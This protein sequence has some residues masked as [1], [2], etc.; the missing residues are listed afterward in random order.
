VVSDAVTWKV[1]VVEGL[2]KDGECNVYRAVN[3]MNFCCSALNP[4]VKCSTV[5]TDGYEVTNLVSSDAD[6]A[7]K[8][9]LAYHA[10][11]PPVTITI[12]FC[13]QV[14]VSHVILWAEV[15]YQKSSGFEIYANC[16]SI[17]KPEEYQK[18]AFGYLEGD[19]VGIIFYR[20]ISY[21][22]CLK[23]AKHL[24]SF[25]WKAIPGGTCCF[26][27]N[28]ASLQIKIIKTKSSVPALARVEVWGKPSNSCDEAVKRNIS[29]LWT[30]T[31]PKKE[32][33]CCE[34]ESQLQ[35]DHD[36]HVDIEIPEEFLDSITCTIMA[37]PFI[38]PC[39]KVVDQSTLDKHG[40][41][42]A[43][44]GR[45]PSDPFTGK[46]FTESSQP[47][48]ATALK[49][50][51][52]KFLI[53]HSDRHELAS[54]PRT[55]GRKKKSSINAMTFSTVPSAYIKPS[56]SVGCP[57]EHKE[58]THPSALED[59]SQSKPKRP[60]CGVDTWEILCDESHEEELDRSLSSAVECTLI[61]L[62]TFTTFN[63]HM[64]I[65][66][67]SVCSS[68]SVL[69]KLPCK[70]FV[71]RACLV[72]KKESSDLSCSVCKACFKSCDPVR[73]HV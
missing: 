58:V 63:S 49:A 20:R 16:A 69:F 23:S 59:V 4:T 40:Q 9:F 34:P 10:V 30:R 11:K 31:I 37:V 29:E 15:G 60:R 52:D 39:G 42:E 17:T 12:N 13:C 43:K 38:L 36:S 68:D 64:V 56:T 73:H 5:S 47:I 25:A 6:E 51:I 50:C 33:V 41:H 7:R 46:I 55:T 66:Q 19:E 18:A 2:L 26:L 53:E 48:P 54:V 57:V 27:N 24:T 45:L 65:Q 8:G 1:A 14:N 70:H 35:S 67:C 22:E 28:A 72:L 44:W 61:G 21:Q 32:T 3:M 71:C 62:P